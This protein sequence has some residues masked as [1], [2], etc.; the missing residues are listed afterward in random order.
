MRAT[1][2]ACLAVL[3][4]LPAAADSPK[5][6][7][8]GPVWDT[9][10]GF[11]F[12]GADKPK[13]L[14]RSLSG[15]AC[16]SESNEPRHCIA[17]FD[18]GGEARYAI[19]DGTRFTPQPERILLLAGNGEL[20]AEGAASHGGFA[21]VTGSHS[22]K[23]E[24]C[25]P[26]PNSR[27]VYRLALQPDGRVQPSS[28]PVDDQGRLWRL[29]SAN[30]TLGPFADKCLGKD[31]HGIN[32]EGLA[33]RNGQLYFGFREPAQDKK[34]YILRV[35]ARAL[36]EGGDLAPR[37]FILEA[38]KASGIRDLLAVP[39]GLLV[40]VGPDDDSKKEVSWWIG[41][42]DGSDASANIALRR[43]AE[44]K[45]PA[46]NGDD[47]QR[48]IKPEAMTLLADGPD[49]RRILIL[50]DGMCDGGPLAFRIRK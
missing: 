27:H 31:G 3:L 10:P 28:Q 41:F 20:D 43:L 50:S 48:E 49:F 6:T 22:R 19:I 13:K 39:E 47:C 23:R 12:P 15:I 17:V 21:Y 25:L 33:V 14:R 37:L 42:W 8:E 2:Y 18:E 32:I 30:P 26:N 38:G 44:L 45:L 24:P 11:A 1:L 29:L 40:L 35:A 9:S 36:F 16:P 5:V 4:A 7:P 46:V 34:A